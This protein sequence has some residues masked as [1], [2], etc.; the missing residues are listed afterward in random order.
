MRFQ[1]LFLFENREVGKDRLNNPIH[2]L[3]LAEVS[4]G[5]FS[6]WSEKEVA[7]DNRNITINNRKILTRAR[8]AVLEKADKV[9]FE[10]LYHSIT[11]IKGSDS[12]RWRIVI[13]N[14]YGSET[15]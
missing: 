11:E 9:R 6:T 1:P 4:S 12:D 14:R 15:P 7:L 2:E 10:G 3:V 8:K 13:V 5:R